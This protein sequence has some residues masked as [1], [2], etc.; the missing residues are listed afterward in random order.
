MPT[1][2][3][4]LKADAKNRSVRTFLTGL[5]IDVAVGIA[6]VLG[7]YF[8]NKNTWGDVEWLLLSFSLFKSFVQAAAA[9]VLRRFLDQSRLPTPLP[10]TDPGEPSDGT[11]PDGAH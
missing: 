6:L 4:Y 11:L 10:P 1:N 2:L 9:F 5:S 3:D 8:A 7:T